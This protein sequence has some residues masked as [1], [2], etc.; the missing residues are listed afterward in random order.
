MM[1]A[2]VLMPISVP[3][4]LRLGQAQPASLSAA[5]L[6]VSVEID[7]LGVFA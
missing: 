6:H 5:R 4:A 7:P 1:T 2:I 3:I